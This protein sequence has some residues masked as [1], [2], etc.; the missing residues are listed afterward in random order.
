[1][2]IKPQLNMRIRDYN[3]AVEIAE[4]EYE[5]FDKEFVY[6]RFNEQNGLVGKGYAEFF[7]F[8]DGN[9]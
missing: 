3:Q 4:T 2:D 1:M 6:Q 8:I 7:D 5:Y 9:D